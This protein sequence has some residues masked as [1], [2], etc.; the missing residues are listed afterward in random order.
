MALESKINRIWTLLSAF[1][2][3]SAACISDML[4]HVSN[5]AYIEGSLMAARF[6]VHVEVLFGS[7]DRL[8][9]LSIN[10]AGYGLQYQKEAKLLCRKIVNF[11]SLLSKTYEVGVRRLGITQ[12]LLSLVT[13]LAHYLKILIRLALTASLRL[14]QDNND[15]TSLEQFLDTLGNLPSNT[16]PSD[17]GINPTSDSCQECSLTIEETCIK[18]TS[19]SSPDR[20]WHINCLRCSL[21]RRAC[22]SDQVTWSESRQKLVCTFC[23]GKRAVQ[24][25]FPDLRKG[26]ERVSLLSQFVFLLR[27][28]LA[29]LGSMLR[30]SKTLPHTSGIRFIYWSL[31]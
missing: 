19:P 20:R 26:F 17:P 8:D 18:F 10:A 4:L 1:E 3:S 13:G 12:E 23:Q 24:K 28:A 9:M 25:D 27:V 2:E 31:R 30:D 6:I 29:R 5:G 15:T 21:C 11:F 22:L 16:P 14:E 7:I